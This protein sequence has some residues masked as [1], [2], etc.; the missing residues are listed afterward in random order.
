M[1]ATDKSIASQPQAELRALGSQPSQDPHL[2][3]SWVLG[4][5]LVIYARNA[6]TAETTDDILNDIA[7]AVEGALEVTDAESG[8][9]HTTL[10]GV[11][12]WARISGEIEIYPGDA[13]GVAEMF[14]PISMLVL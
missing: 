7:D 14:V 1:S 6:G 8:D 2:V 5:M 9:H 4:A 12:E 13:G 10:G 11:V 3:P